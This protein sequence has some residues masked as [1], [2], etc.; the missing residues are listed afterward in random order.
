MPKVLAE[1]K[2]LA[3]D[4]ISPLPMV[5][6]FSQRFLKDVRR[7]MRGGGK[8]G[9]GGGGGGARLPCDSLS[10]Q[11][12]WRTLKGTIPLISGRTANPVTFAQRDIDLA[13]IVLLWAKMPQGSGERVSDRGNFS[14][15]A[16]E[17]EE[18]GGG[19]GGGEGLPQK[20]HGV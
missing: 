19:G 18:E 7:K 15:A 1:S 8:G 6:C 9:G 12:R 20:W 13:G 4:R 17:G 5:E 14:L 11:P 2:V 3:E 10:R 16:G